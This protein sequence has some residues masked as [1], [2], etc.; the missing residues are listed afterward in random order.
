ML[1]R[2]LIAIFVLPVIG[3]FVFLK[4]PYPVLIT[5]IV[6]LL[7]ALYEIF[8][9]FEKNQINVFKKTGILSAT[10]IFIFSILNYD[11]I[12]IF[13]TITATIIFLFL[14]LIFTKSIVNLQGVFF[15]LG[16]VLYICL[17]G[18]FII[19]LRLSE[20][21]IYHLF[22]LPL[23][24]WVYDAGAYFTGKFFGKHKL[25]PELSPGKTKEGFIGGIII[26]IIVTLI[27]KFTVLPASLNFKIYDAI[28][29]PILTSFFGQAG[30]ITASIIKRFCGVKNSSSLLSEHGGFLDK[31]DSIL[32]NAPI[33]YFY[34][35]FFVI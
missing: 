22:L 11:T 9:M 20:N 15:T 1:K 14:I 29:L 24:T 32:F 7:I 4:N 26:N 35:Q 3:F 12:Y 19:K 33:I 5:G 6:A 25:I 18:I 21:G 2:I 28:F 31:L 16:A 13:Y 10:V 23:L 34:V 17:L 8:I 30:D 27:I